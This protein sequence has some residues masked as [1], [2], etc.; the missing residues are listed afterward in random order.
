MF[1]RRMCMKISLVCVFLPMVSL[2]AAPIH[3]AVLNG[4]R[5]AVEQLLDEGAD[6]DDRSDFGYTALHIAV[7][8]GDIALVGLLIERSADVNLVNEMDVSP[9]M[10]AT[11][12]GYEGIARLLRQS[13]ATEG[14]EIRVEQVIAS[15]EYISVGGLATLCSST[16]ESSA[17]FCDG[18][19]RTALHF[20]KLRF[21]CMSDDPADRVYCAGADEAS[22][23]ISQEFDSC[24]DCGFDDISRRLPRCVP[25][26]DR[27]A[28]YC[29]A[30]NTEL[31]SSTAMG[32]F[33]D[34]SPE[35]WG[36]AQAGGEMVG[37]GLGGDPSLSLQNCVTTATPQEAL[38]EAFL[39]FVAENPSERRGTAF[40]GIIRAQFYQMCDDLPPGARPHL[41]L[42]TDLRREMDQLETINTCNESVVL[43][44][45]TGT[46]RPTQR[47]LEPGEPF[48]IDVTR[49]ARWLST[50]CPVGYEST[51]PLSE[52]NRSLIAESQYSCIPAK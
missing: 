31:E 52:D 28:E 5:A 48:S 42:C 6:V 34:D 1:L 50:A 11:L 37:H 51:V 47:T 12:S 43:T 46:R 49:G 36:V 9:L 14:P 22:D 7:A 39:D 27:S 19:M 35:M 18:Y 4:D 13:G 41:E 15:S 45:D 32:S 10:S 21:S 30:Y 8:T 29:E 2:M 25:D 26:P 33:E 17:A 3:D 44:I 20:R 24:P 16:L 40:A 38:R 23:A